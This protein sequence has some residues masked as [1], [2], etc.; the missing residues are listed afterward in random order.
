MAV[1]LEVGQVAK[2]EN[3]WLARR[4][5]GCV[6]WDA[7]ATVERRVDQFSDGRGCDSGGPER[8]YSLNTIGHV[9]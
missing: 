4:I 7:A 3:T 6:D 1:L 9:V 8:D 2:N 5:Q